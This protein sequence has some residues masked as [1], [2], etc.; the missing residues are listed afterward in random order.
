[1][2]E[3]TVVVVVVGVVV[4]VM[5]KDEVVPVVKEKRAG[6]EIGIIRCSRS[7]LQ[8]AGNAEKGFAACRAK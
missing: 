6:A 2:L 4:V 3:T 7:F 5:V 8:A 1:L